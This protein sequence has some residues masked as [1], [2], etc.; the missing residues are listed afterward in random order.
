MAHSGHKKGSR[1]GIGLG[2]E[3][4]RVRVRFS[5]FA[6]VRVRVR[7]MVRVMIPVRGRAGVM[8]VYILQEY[9]LRVF[10]SIYY[11]Y[12]YACRY[13]PVYTGIYIYSS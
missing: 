4:V 9:I 2:S 3:E 10:T 7:V 5:A 12:I 6:S 1:L 11:E 8:S 13:I